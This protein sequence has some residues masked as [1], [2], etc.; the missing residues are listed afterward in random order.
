MGWGR[1]KELMDEVIAAV[2][3]HTDYETSKA[4]FKRLIPVWN[5]E[6]CDDLDECRGTSIPFRDAFDELDSSILEEEIAE[7]MDDEDED[8]EDD[9]DD[10][11]DFDDGFEDDEDD[12]DD[13]DYE[14]D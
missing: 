1:G 11:D 8:D 5:G 7:E 10:D 2:V 14:D 12:E 3:A 13:E 9:Y 4:I 6:D